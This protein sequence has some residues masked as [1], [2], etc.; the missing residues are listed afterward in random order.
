L[1]GGPG[2]DRCDNAGIVGT[3]GRD[4]RVCTPR[5]CYWIYVRG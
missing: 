2:L 3:C 4:V 5:I 1:H